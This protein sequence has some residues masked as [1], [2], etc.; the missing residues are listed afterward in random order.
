MNTKNPERESWC[1]E[2]KMEQMREKALYLI[3]GLQ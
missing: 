2:L 3:F 1:N